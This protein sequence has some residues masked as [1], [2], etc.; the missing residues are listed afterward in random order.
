MYSIICARI[1]FSVEVGQTLVLTPAF[2]PRRRRI[3]SPPRVNRPITAV[4]WGLRCHPR[5]CWHRAWPNCSSTPQA[6]PSP[7]GR[8]SGR[9][10]AGPDQAVQRM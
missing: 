3:I 7:S 10:W 9:G 5:R 8:G 1:K 4:T 6:V 2:S